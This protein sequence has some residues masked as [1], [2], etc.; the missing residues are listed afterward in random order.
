MDGDNNGKPYEQMDDLGGFPII[1]GNTHINK[2]ISPKTKNI[3]LVGLVSCLRGSS[4]NP[5]W[6]KLWISSTA[7]ASKWMQCLFWKNG[8]SGSR[9]YDWYS[10]EEK[11]N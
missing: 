7:P 5:H 8:Q 4:E 6:Q 9:Y 11:S 2:T 1:F 10:S 3:A